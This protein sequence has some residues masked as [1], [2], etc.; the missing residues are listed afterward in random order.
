LETSEKTNINILFNQTKTR[1][2]SFPT[3]DFGV[4]AGARENAL[5][6]QETG[7][8]FWAKVNAIHW[9]C[10]AFVVVGVTDFVVV[11]VMDFDWDS[12]DV[13]GCENGVVQSDTHISSPSLCG[14]LT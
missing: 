2:I 4:E 12:C 8:D 6:A 11:E 9:N 10:R 5:F 7:F 13:D 1:L 3:W 14:R